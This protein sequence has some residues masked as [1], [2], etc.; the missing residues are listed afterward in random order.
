M[1]KLGD[2]DDIVNISSFIKMKQLTYDIVSSHFHDLPCTEPRFLI[3][4]G[5]ASSGKSYLIN[6]L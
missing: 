1:L 2:P 4:I 3:M 6:A 5:Q